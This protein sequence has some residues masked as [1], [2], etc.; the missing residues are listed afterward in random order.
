[1]VNRVKNDKA[2]DHVGTIMGNMIESYGDRIV[3]CLHCDN[4]MKLY[5]R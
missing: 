4:Y 2:R 1:M 3:L 5:M